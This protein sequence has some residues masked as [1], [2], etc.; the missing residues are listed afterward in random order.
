MEQFEQL[1]QRDNPL[2][3]SIKERGFEIPSEIQEKSIPSI[4]E[5]KDVIAGASTGSGKT[6]AFAAGLVK[7]VKKDQGVQGL[8]ITPTRELAEQITNELA[9]FSKYKGL[10]VTSVYGGVSIHNQI[11]LINS[12]EIV[13][14]TPGR[15]LDHLER[16]SINL[17]RINTLVLDEVD[18]MFDMGFIEDVRKII[19]ECPNKRQTLLFSATI[20]QEIVRI[21]ERYMKDPIEISAQ[22]YV[23]PNKL[24]QV[25][26]DI[27]DN[28]KYSLLNYLLK[29]EKSKLVMIF[30]NTRKNVDF[31]AKNLMFSGLEVVPMHGGFT[32]DKRNRFLEQF[33]K[34]QVHILVTT[35]VAARGLDIKG[36]SH[37]YNYDLPPTLDDY[38]HR[39]GRTARAGK[40]GK[41]INILASRDY[42]NF[43]EIKGSGKFNIAS[44]KTPF[45]QRVRIRWMPEK[46]HERFNRR[47]T[48]H[49]R[50]SN[51]NY[52]N[53]NRNSDNDRKSNFRGNRDNRGNRNRNSDNDRGSNFRGNRN[54]R[55]NRDSNNR[56][57]RDNNRSR[58][59]NRNRNNFSRNRRR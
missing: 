59:N 33:H 28:L 13:V 39:I 42:K 34:N 43:Q 45:L 10:N 51:N 24:K 2:L 21:S 44:E 23:D 29:N 32:Q 53:N 3:K 36:V 56:Y 27:D 18:R 35:D 19:A 40:E 26:Y 15:L 14:A 58:N 41:V 12:A 20:S 54:P 22:Q 31:I 50:N 38:T 16:N 1:L 11:K 37:V 9:D 30:C 52:K 4:L 6:L 7:N 5:G 57:N 17:S 46:K 25:Y 47:N 8:V 48:N 55:N 49:E